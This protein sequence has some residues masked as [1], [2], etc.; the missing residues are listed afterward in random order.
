VAT[1]AATLVG[2]IGNGLVIRG[3]TAAPSAIPEPATMILLGTGLACIAAK[4]RRRKSRA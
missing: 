1:G 2:F 3:L 4:V